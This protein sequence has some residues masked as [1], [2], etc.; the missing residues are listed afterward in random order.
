MCYCTVFALFCFE[1]EGSFQVQA[2][3][4]LYLEGRFNGG[5]LRYE[6]GELIFGGAYFRNFAVC[7][8]SNNNPHELCTCNK[9]FGSCTATT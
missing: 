3:R 6:Y 5:F 7:V 1:F 9:I 2:P 8:I 4:G